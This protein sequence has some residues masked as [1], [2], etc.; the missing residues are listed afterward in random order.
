MSGD[1]SHIYLLLFKKK[2]KKKLRLI[3]TLELFKEFFQKKNSPPFR[4]SLIYCKNLFMDQ[5]TC[6]IQRERKIPSGSSE[7]NL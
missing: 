4:F 7:I 1:L 6:E 5:R 2:T 3:V